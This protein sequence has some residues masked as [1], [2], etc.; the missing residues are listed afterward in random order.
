V[1]TNCLT[2]DGMEFIA[3]FIDGYR[4]VGG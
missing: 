2:G 3:D 1:L 4:R